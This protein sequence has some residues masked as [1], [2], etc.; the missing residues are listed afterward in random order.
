MYKQI[1]R[2]C[3]TVLKQ[4]LPSYFRRCQSVSPVGPMQTCV[5]SYAASVK[6]DVQA[7]Y[8]VR[9]TTSTTNNSK[10]RPSVSHSALGLGLLNRSVMPMVQS[11]SCVCTTS[12]EASSFATKI[13]QKTQVHFQGQITRAYGCASFG[14]NAWNRHFQWDDRRPSCSNVRKFHITGLVSYTAK[15]EGSQNDP[16]HIQDKANDSSTKGSATGKNQ[17]DSDHDV[18][19]RMRIKISTDM[20][21]GGHLLVF[22]FPH[23]S[24][25]K[26]DNHVGLA[27]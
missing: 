25:Y 18:W 27:L 20:A 16:V 24:C 17:I 6:K 2:N 14:R 8:S 22:M 5:G 13:D 11:S 21:V 26:H 3:E 4:N 9:P 7:N 1:A 15:T 23:A 10:N 19:C 12:S